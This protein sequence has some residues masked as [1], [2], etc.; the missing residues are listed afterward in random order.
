[1]SALV[2]VCKLVLIFGAVCVSECMYCKFMYGKVNLGLAA[3]FFN[4]IPHFILRYYNRFKSTF[5]G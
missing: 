3:R 4:P 2:E 5:I 1:M